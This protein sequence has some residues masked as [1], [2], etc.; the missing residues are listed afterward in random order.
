MLQRTKAVSSSGPQ[1]SLIVKLWS[2]LMF[3]VS[4]KTLA[5]SICSQLI[6]R[7]FSLCNQNVFRD[8][9][10]FRLWAVLEK[11]PPSSL[12]LKELWPER[13]KQNVA[14][15][16]F[17]FLRSQGWVL[18][19]LRLRTQSQGKFMQISSF[20]SNQLNKP[21]LQSLV[22]LLNYNINFKKLPKCMRQ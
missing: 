21:S 16:L 20:I 13:L 15:A 8:V 2:H 9:S 11:D 4:H 5:T 7:C 1:Y 12:H 17:F 6:L 18:K 22:R 10:G 19:W 14:T 3:S